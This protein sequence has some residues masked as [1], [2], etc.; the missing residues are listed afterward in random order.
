MTDLHLFGVWWLPGNPSHQ[1]Q[2]TLTQEPD[3]KLTLSTYAE[4]RDDAT[5]D[6][7]PQTLYGL[8]DRTPVTITD[9]HW[10]SSTGG[11]DHR[12]ETWVAWTALT[13][14]HLEEGQLF[15][16]VE[17]VSD[18]LDAWVD[19]KL[20]RH[21]MADERTITISNPPAVEPAVYD[22]GRLWLGHGLSE[23]TGNRALTIK[24][25]TGIGVTPEHPMTLSQCVDHVRHADSLLDAIFGL[26][27][28]ALDVYLRPSGSNGRPCGGYRLVG[29][30]AAPRFSLC[31]ER[32]RMFSE[33]LCP[34]NDFGGVGGLAKWFGLERNYRYLAG[35]VMSHYRSEGRYLEDTALAA[36]AAGEALERAESPTKA[37]ART[38]W[39]RLAKRIPVFVQDFI[40]LSASDWAREVVDERNR[41][42]HMSGPETGDLEAT[43]MIVFSQSAHFLCV[44]SLLRIAGLAGA[45][46][47]LATPGMQTGYKWRGL[48]DN[49]QDDLRRVG[50]PA[51]PTPA[52]LPGSGERAALPAPPTMETKVSDD[53][54]C[55]RS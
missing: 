46:T 16:S 23:T 6:G 7:G 37:S 13:G 33:Q 30:H 41:L 52:P 28:S 32:S 38:R 14:L 4:L 8:M 25:S 36:F 53:A 47:A 29:A 12:Q 19:A 1:V 45:L 39:E 48:R 21:E 2:G 10:W 3:G 54:L 11:Y 44:L 35:R 49:Y 5:Y 22:G 24:R 50:L 31:P 9:A 26:P 20:W 43:R 40:V 51:P 34:F 18:Y 55:G 27:T 17:V 42:A 15:E